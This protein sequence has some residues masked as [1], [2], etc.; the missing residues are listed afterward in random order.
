MCTG[1]IT[2]NCAPPPSRRRRKAPSQ[3]GNLH[4]LCC[5]AI[6]AAMLRS[7]NARKAQSS[8]EA[9]PR[10]AAMQRGRWL[11]RREADRHRRGGD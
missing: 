11:V 10:S 8:Y 4:P 7:R 3:R 6:G 5:Y 9:V 1:D 2:E